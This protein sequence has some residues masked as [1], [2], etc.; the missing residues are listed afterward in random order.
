MIISSPL[1]IGDTIGVMSPSSYIT[2]DDL[3]KAVKI[4]EGYGYKIHA[5]PQTLAKHNQSAGTNIEKL[6][7]FHDLIQNP[8]IKAII[9]SCGGNRAMHWVDDIDYDIIKANPKIIMGFSD[10]TSILNLINA[11]V[12]L[13]TYHGP[14]LKWFMVHENNK[15]DIEQCFEVLSNPSKKLSFLRKQ[16]SDAKDP[17]FRWDD[18]MLTGGNLSLIQYLTSE[19]DFNKKI[20]FIEDRYIE[21]SR[22]DR[23]ICH[24]KRM[25][26]FKKIDG[27]ILGEFSQL[28]DTERPYGFTFD[29]IIAEHVPHNLPIIRNA[30]FG[31]GKRLITLPIG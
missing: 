24:L 9:F 7:A 12:G 11:R 4:V 27:L 31:H 6:N 25:N 29:D 19:L 18:K 13:V 30:P 1:Q 15:T 2:R 17:S 26:V 28:L 20:L 5:H 22:L 8:D 3:D 10:I 14:N 21:I 16:E 23:M